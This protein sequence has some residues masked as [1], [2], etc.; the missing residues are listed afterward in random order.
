MAG[1]DRIGI[2]MVGAGSIARARHVPGFKAIPGVELVGVVNRTPESSKAA[3]KELGFARTYRDWRALLDDPKVD[4]VVVAAWPYLHAPVTLAALHAGK[5]VLTQARMATDADEARDMLDASLEHPD[6]ATMVVPAPNGWGDR[7]IMRLLAEGAIG[8][9]RTV[10]L[11]WGG[12]V[13][14]GHPDPWRRQRRYSGYNIMAVG[15]LYEGIA[16]WLGHATAVQAR[17]ELYVDAERATIG[18]TLYDVPDY[19]AIQAEFPNRVHA[20]IEISAHASF[21]GANGAHLFGTEGTLFVDFDAH[22]LRLSTAQA[23][24]GRPVRIPKN[25][26]ADWRVEAEFIGAIRGEEEV[27]LTDFATGVRYMAFTDAVNESAKNGVRVA[28]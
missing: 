10:R 7:T 8:E 19:V 2:G 5:H 25:E 6:L 23:P 21:A 15:I 18:T 4:A 28:L 26:L 17:T 13:S 3:A 22:A 11:A 14:G 16:R 1:A 27:R 24:E 9:L 20:S 12:S